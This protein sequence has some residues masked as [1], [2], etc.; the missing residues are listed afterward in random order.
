[1]KSLKLLIVVS[2][3]VLILPIAAAAST[4]LFD[5]VPDSNMFVDDINWLKNEG[6]TNGCNVAGTEF[7]PEAPVLRQEMAAFM[8]RLADSRA[9]DAGE[10]GG[11]SAGSFIYN[12]DW[13]VK[14]ESKGVGV[15]SI[16]TTTVYCPLGKYVVSGG[17][18]ATYRQ[19][20]LMSSHP[21]TRFGSKIYTGWAV[22]WA[23]D[24]GPGIISATL[25][26]NALCAGN[27]R[28]IVP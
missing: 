12:A 16:V 23:N 27:S 9:V 1:M 24:S 22:T 4:S 5:D 10:L 8:H 19:L 20:S 18:S 3:V 25:T 26:A 7:C 15:G 21:I 11:M 28:V 6:I 17:G 13:E 2:V 14:S